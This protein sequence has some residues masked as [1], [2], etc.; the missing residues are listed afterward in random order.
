[1]SRQECLN[2]FLS[3]TP[4]QVLQISVEFKLPSASYKRRLIS[5]NQRFSESL[6]LKENRS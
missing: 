4:G 3:I 6:D 2:K 1:M 5:E